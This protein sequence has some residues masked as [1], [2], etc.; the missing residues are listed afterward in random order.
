MAGRIA[1][2]AGEK[3]A[4]GHEPIIFGRFLLAIWVGLPDLE[5]VA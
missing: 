4:C 2:F 3:N 1:R 5:A